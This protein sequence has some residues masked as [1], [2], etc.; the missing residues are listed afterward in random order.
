MRNQ[1]RR[2]GQPQQK[3]AR[4]QPGHAQRVSMVERQKAK[5]G[6]NQHGYDQERLADRVVPG[7]EEHRLQLIEE[8]DRY[9]T[10]GEIDEVAGYKKKQHDPGNEAQLSDHPF[11][12]SQRPCSSP[13][14]WLVFC[15]Q[16]DTTKLTWYF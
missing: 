5:Q 10:E 12:L 6:V 15:R 16:K 1:E 3:L 11:I 4:I 13:V 14:N 2:N 9:E 7:C 8:L